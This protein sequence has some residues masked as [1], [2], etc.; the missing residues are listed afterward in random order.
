MPSP[1]VSIIIPTFNA[2][3]NIK[4]CFGSLSKQVYRNFEVL[5]V[6][7]FS[8]DKTVEISRQYGA[9]ILV[10][11]CTWSEALMLGVEN[12]RGKYYFVVESSLEI[13]P[14]FIAECV[15]KAE[16]EPDIVG[17][18]GPEYSQGEGFWAQCMNLE[19][20][21]N[22]GYEVVEAPRFIRKTAYYQAGGYDTNIEFG[23]DW[24]FFRR[25]RRIGRVSRVQS[26]WI[27]HEGYPT[28]FA[29]MVKKY[30]YGRTARRYLVKSVASGVGP[31]LFLQLLPIRPNFIRKTGVWRRVKFS[32]VLG[33]IFLK[34]VESIA[35]MAAVLTS[36]IDE[37]RGKDIR[38][39]HAQKIRTE[40]RTVTVTENRTAAP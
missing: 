14:L 28:P 4:T 6:D 20:L 21:L 26:G 16:S 32:T 5:V 7:N 29:L 22:I 11:Q 15:E 1:L 8:R 10:A 38:Y 13:S 23:D 27:H 39:G 36:A 19:R 31:R 40:A 2:E 25:L 34:I 3:R 33:Y 18:I 12:A 9:R 35:V 24:D 30:K 17:L 37:A